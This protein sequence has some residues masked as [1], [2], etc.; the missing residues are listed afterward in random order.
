MARPLERVARLT[1]APLD[2]VALAIAAEFRPLDEAAATAGLDRLARGL[3]IAG[4]DPEARADAMLAVMSRR[5]GFDLAPRADPDSLFLDWVIET[6]RGDPLALAIVYA[7]V[8]RRAGFELH[9]VGSPRFLL[10]GDPSATPPI[11]IDPVPGGRRPPRSMR[12]LCPHL[13]GAAMLG[14]LERRFLERGRIDAAIRAAELRLV[15]PLGGE[16]RRRHQRELIALRAR[17]N[18]RSSLVQSA[19]WV[20]SRE[21]APR[22]GPR[23]CS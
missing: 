17:L 22:P 20:A 7:A 18:R 4:L 15:L 19:E 6:R 9:P 11:A 14:A 21:S 5:H 12:W 8:A 1:G 3:A 13:V 23:R 16:L 10:L 2:L